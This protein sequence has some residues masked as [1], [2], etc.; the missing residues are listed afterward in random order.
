M[1]E[2][3]NTNRNES[4]VVENPIR[5]WLLN[6]L[7]SLLEKEIDDRNQLKFEL[8]CAGLIR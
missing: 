4:A 3:V 2:N 1:N 7:L 5:N 6:D 8:Y